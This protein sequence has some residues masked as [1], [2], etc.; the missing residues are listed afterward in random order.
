MPRRTPGLKGRISELSK[1]KLIKARVLEVMGN[2]VSV[3]LS[4]N[5]SKLFGI[6]LVG[7]PVEVGDTVEVNYSS[8]TPIAEA[9]GVDTHR[10]PPTYRYKPPITDDYEY[11]PPHPTNPASDQYAIFL[12]DVSSGSAAGRILEFPVSVDGLN[13]ALSVASYGDA[14]TLP[15]CTLIT[16]LITIPSG[17]SLTGTSREMSTLDCEVYLGD[18][19]NIYNLSIKRTKNNSSTLK[20]VICSSGYAGTVLDSA[21]E[22]AQN[23]SGDVRCVSVEGNGSQCRIRNSYF[24]PSAASGSAHGFWVETG[25]SAYIGARFCYVTGSTPLNT[26]TNIVTYACQFNAYY[27]VMG[28][29]G[30]GDRAPY[31]HYHSSGSDGGTLFIPEVLDDLSD[32]DVP[33]PQLEEYLIWGG[34]E[35]TSGSVPHHHKLGYH[36][37]VNA[38]YPIDGD[39]LLWSD[40][41][42]AWTS[43]SIGA[44]GGGTGLKYKVYLYDESLGV[45]SPYNANYSGLSDAISAAASGDVIFFPN[46]TIAGNIT[47][48][49]GVSIVGISREQSILDGQVTIGDDSSIENMSIITSGSTAGTIKGIASVASK[50]FYVYDC[51]IEITQNGPGS[52][53]ALSIEH[54]TCFIHTHN[55]LLYGKAPSS[56][57]GYAAYKASGITGTCYIFGGRAVGQS[58]PFLEL[59]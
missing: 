33:D 45:V 12:H 58:T 19:A 11:V 40:A 29:A 10:D 39:A 25:T 46:V 4:D 57:N 30:K 22:L 43:G 37:D 41:V 47:V 31:H 3:Q 26:N 53:Y 52:A 23:G 16:D 34:A 56:G 9:T 17:V 28:T 55:C 51:N 21:I 8:G 54:S 42:S 27:D 35:W 50:T 13:D 18:E 15:S 20:G 6:L 14:V 24:Q 36:L 59:T 32:V 7:G 49:D 1:S 5:A 48:P 2:Y 38:H 44:G